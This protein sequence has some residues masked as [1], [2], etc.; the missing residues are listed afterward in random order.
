MDLAEIHCLPN[1]LAGD[2]EMGGLIRK[3]DWSRTPL[4]PVEQWSPSLRMMI[5]FMLANRFPLLLW[6]G[7]EYISIYNDAYI[8]VLGAKHPQALGQPVREC[9]SE[10]WDVLKPLIDTP[11]EGG[12]STWTE[13]LGLE[14]N[15][16][17]FLEETHFTVA[18]SP[19]PDE[20]APRGIGGVLATV[21]EITD[22][23]IGKRQLAL[24]RELAA[25][26][27]NSQAEVA[28]ACESAANA[29]G[30]DRRD[31]PFAMIY[32]AEPDGASL[33]LKGVSGI[34][35]GSHAA[36]LNV[37]L[38]A[39]CL[40]PLA[41][42]VRDRKVQLVEN[43]AS[44]FG[45]EFPAGAWDQS[46][47]QAALI[48]IPAR[49][50]TGRPGVMI[51]GLNPFR[52][53][54]D[55]Y[56]RFLDLAAGEI[57]AGIANA[58][59]YEE[60]RRRAEA[61]A[62]IDRAKTAFFSNVS[63]E[64]RTPLTLMLGPLE[65]ALRSPELPSPERDRL[66]VA[67]RNSL[68]LLKLVNSLLDFSRIE[69]G[70]ARATYQAT[71]LGAFTAELASNFE[72]ACERA[73]L[74][75]VIDCPSLAEPVYV[76][77][78]MWEKIVL[79]LLSN[80]FKFTFEGRITV[81]LR[82]VDGRAELRVRDTG[83]GVPRDELPRLFERFHRIEGQRSRT[84]EGSGIG[85]ALVQELV[86]LHGGNLR[87]G[88]EVGLG[89]EFFVDIPLGTAHLRPDRIVGETAAAAPQHTRAWA[90]ETLGWLQEAE[91][92]TAPF[93]VKA[94]EIAVPRA[95]ARILVA[96]DNLDMRTYVS[97]LL[98]RV[99]EV[100]AVPDGQA[101]LEAIREQRPDLVLT[102][103][104]MPR[105]DGFQLLE[106]IRSDPALRDIP[107]IMLSAQAGEEAK[108]EGLEAGADDY[109]VKP[110]SAHE[111]I[112]RVGANL[113][114]GKLRH[115]TMRTLRKNDERQRF[116]LKLA[117]VLRPLRDPV[118]IQEEA[119]RLLG[120]HLG[121]SRALYVQFEGE[122]EQEQIVIRR[123]YHAEDVASIA[124]RIPAEAMGRDIRELH[125]GRS[126]A[127][128]DIEAE[129]PSE[130]ER[131][132]WRTLGVRAYAG[133]PLIKDG[134]L[135][136][137]FGVHQS[138]PRTWSEEELAL[139]RETAERTWST[140]ERVC[141]EEALRR[142][143]ERLEILDQIAK[144][145][146]S[147]LDTERIVQLV[148]DSATSLTGAKFGAFFYNVTDAEGESYLLYALSGAPRAAFEKF[149]LPRNTA[150]F[151][152]T[153]RGEG[154]IRSADIRKDPRYG[155][156]SPHFGMPKGH[157]PVVSYLAVPV[158]SRS[159]KVIGGLFFGHD[160]PGVFTA[161]SEDLVAGI[162]AHAALAVDNAMLLQTTQTEV[163]QRK[164]AESMQA[165]QR[166][167]LELSVTDAP[168]ETVLDALV[169]TIEEQS[170]AGMLGSILL[171]DP[172]GK[173]LRHGAAPSLPKTYNDAIDGVTMGPMVGSCGTAAFLKQ[174]VQVSDI[175]SDPL[176]KDFRDLAA[177]HG[178]KACWSLP[179]LSSRGRILGTYAMYYRL[180]QEPV[181]E[182]LRLV[183]VGTHTAAL[184]I[185]RKRAE[186][187]RELLIHE[188]NHRVKNTL[189]TVQS[190]VA[191]TLR[192]S[193][194]GAVRESLEE[195]LIAMSQAHDVLT[196]ENW[197]SAEIREVV[198]SAVA[199]YSDEGRFEIEGP[200]IRLK[201]GA[202]LAISMALHE[203]V[204]NAVKYGALSN[205]DGKVAV[206]WWSAPDGDQ[207]E[208]GH[209][210]LSWMETGGPPVQTPTRRGF[211]SRLIEEGLAHDLGGRVRLEFSEAGLAFDLDAPLSEV[212]G[213]D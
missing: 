134:R 188:L 6:W 138:K 117:D 112:A 201:P 160:Q 58:Q 211:G 106:A 79:N 103:V 139:I 73:G 65:D 54:G 135:V 191:L 209:F 159:G 157:L 85:L 212:R 60:E 40:W 116:L 110:F 25:S 162:A 179:I 126:V 109:L 114:L 153:F 207:S 129:L 11:F 140:V 98:D 133:L 62:E 88:S 193:E 94:S 76:D 206:H 4:G 47:T 167:V 185:E 27:T 120:L 13:D 91:I 125:A 183:E 50:D 9:W 97:R 187:H 154:A 143:T 147:D 71:D 96:D 33:S 3:R 39:A 104:M 108:V 105:L 204:T 23:I 29:L 70:R 52:L 152:P 158:I 81:R 90:A 2:G 77:R 168:L 128:S 92:A 202:A 107:V 149:G 93:G 55:D 198:S 124:G 67:H 174:P 111:L 35:P 53:F 189:A 196:R 100:H 36:P 169:R 208:S 199:A 1:F 122:G 31:L 175:A 26:L 42:V 165:A 68:R 18:Y 136:A 43:I 51:A 205:Q 123:D 44:R 74:E 99:A 132:T 19:V 182:D 177:E 115:E 5:G 200:N 101:A 141:A 161:E 95:G 178:L 41:Q 64:F 148:T 38:D 180:T 8:P 127:V 78:D 37:R 14:I 16:N 170:Q 30:R 75:L 113:T 121:A 89:T 163:E 118:A 210:Y 24:L 173:H 87:A 197:E 46:S 146:A 10:I 190:V 176:W 7:P 15:R 34:E 66:E 45:M 213:G 184:V 102:D 119:S 83:V 203:L 194:P 57:G 151:G 142:Q 32:L 84:Y 131:Q 22:E 144:A 164:R 192:N 56:R 155:K 166:R 69:A 61:L 28:Q 195:R 156:S 20:T 17:G 172:D 49:G 171:L 63:H 181:V 137:A 12:P 59:A 145:L 150:I 21:H 82:A 86:K 186:A 48:P 80:A 72:S 130:E